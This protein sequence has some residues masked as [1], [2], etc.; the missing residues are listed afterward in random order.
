MYQGLCWSDKNSM[1]VDLPCNDS[2]VVFYDGRIIT[3]R[4][5]LIKTL[6]YGPAIATD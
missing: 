1:N 6:L 3:D 2:H 4:I 5:D